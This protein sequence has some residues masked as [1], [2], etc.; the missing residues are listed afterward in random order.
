M[1][2]QNKN[3]QLQSENSRRSKRHREP[4]PGWSADTQ[5]SLPRDFDDWLQSERE[6]LVEKVLLSW[7]QPNLRP[8]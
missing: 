2:H 4:R 6:Q 3:M 5:P 8:Q 7:H 1:K